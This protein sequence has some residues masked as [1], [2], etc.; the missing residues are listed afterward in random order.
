MSLNEG[1]GEL[2]PMLIPSPSCYLERL[3]TGYISLR[4]ISP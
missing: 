2:E 1:Q 3:G 4:S